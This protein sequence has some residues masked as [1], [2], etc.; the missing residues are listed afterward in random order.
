M[1]RLRLSPPEV[2]IAGQ[3]A[4]MRG[5]RN[6]ERR[7]HERYGGTD[8]LGIDPHFAGIM[9]EMTV[10]KKIDRYYCGNFDDFT[11]AD[12]GS[13]LQVRAC[14]EPT[15]RLILHPYDPHTNKGDKDGDVFISA[16]IERGSW[17]RKTGVNVLLRGWIFG[18][19]G[20]RPEWWEDGKKGKKRPAFFVPNSELRPIEDIVGYDER[21]RSGG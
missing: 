15:D 12:L 14:S 9:G 8:L 17:T 13:H 19:D 10:A 3:L 7:L 11:A 21:E 5:I 6:L 4:Q 1:I 20:K 16:Q 18:R 2:W